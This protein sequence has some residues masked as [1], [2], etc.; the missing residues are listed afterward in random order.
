[1]SA[2]ESCF[3]AFTIGLSMIALLADLLKGNKDGWMC[4]VLRHFDGQNC[5]QVQYDGSVVH[6]IFFVDQGGKYG[7]PM[8]VCRVGF[9]FCSRN[10]CGRAME[11]EPLLLA[12]HIKLEEH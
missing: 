9:I 3:E 11:Q 6:Y 1:M 4:W 5:W 2:V 7:M 12:A 8:M 10:K